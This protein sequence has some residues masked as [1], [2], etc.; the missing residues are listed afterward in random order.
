MESKSILKVHHQPTSV[1]VESKSMA[2]SFQPLLHGKITISD[3]EIFFS[4]SF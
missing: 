3:P 1:T 4:S 2:I